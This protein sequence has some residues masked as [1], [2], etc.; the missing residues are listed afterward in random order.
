MA[1]V[2][3][4]L[5]ATDHWCCGQVRRVGD[6]VSMSVHNCEGI[7]IEE[8]HDV[9]ADLGCRT[10]GGDIVAMV[11]RPIVFRVEH[12]LNIRDGY[13][14]ATPISSTEDDVPD[15]SP[16]AFEFM[17]ET[18]DRIPDPHSKFSPSPAG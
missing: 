6:E 5:D 3:V 10:I 7:V 12:G 4:L 1:M 8:R 15:D 9:D 13:G 14:V 11:W 16:W 17:L 2:A 18:N